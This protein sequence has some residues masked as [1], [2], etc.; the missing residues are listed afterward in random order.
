MKMN[1]PRTNK[2]LSLSILLAVAL[3]FLSPL[4]SAELPPYVYIAHANQ[5]PE[6]LLIRVI[7]VRKKAN[8]ESSSVDVIGEVTQVRRS[9]SGLAPGMRLQ[10]VYDVVRHPPG[11]VGPSQPP[12]LQ[13]GKTVPAFVALDGSN[14]KHYRL[15]AGGQSFSQWVWDKSGAEEKP[16]SEPYSVKVRVESSSCDQQIAGQAP[17]ALGRLTWQWIGAHQLQAQ[18]SQLINTRTEIVD[19]DAQATVEENVL[20]ITYRARH[21]PQDG[22]PVPA[23]LRPVRVTFDVSGLPRRDYQVQLKEAPGPATDRK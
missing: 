11:W 13:K 5:A 17:P 16:S 10:I 20:T 19:S 1:P 21:Q 6:A 8:G 18:I 14:A 9:A 7:D 4:A 3:Q 15:A 12:V 22:K 23:C 2:A